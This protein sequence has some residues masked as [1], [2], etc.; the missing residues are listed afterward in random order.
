MNINAAFWV[1]ISFFIFCGALIYLKVPQLIH[2]SLNERILAIKRELEEA[3]KLK[4]E[5]KDLLSNYE[6]K[7]IKAQKETSDI[8]NNAKKESEKIIVDS[9]EKFHKTMENKKKATEQKIVQMKEDSLKDIKNASVNITF[10]TVE[11]LI[12]NSIDKNKLDNI[13]AKNLEQAKIALKKVI[14]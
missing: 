1:A 3:V 9:T 13:Y 2:N 12:K 6:N 11:E 4:E 8:I 14:T 5:A 7:I 10:K